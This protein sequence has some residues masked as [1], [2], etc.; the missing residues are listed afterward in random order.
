MRASDVRQLREEEKIILKKLLTGKVR[1][2]LFDK[3]VT[4]YSFAIF[5]FPHSLLVH[6]LIGS[7]YT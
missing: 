3:L 2:E 6:R 4:A 5:F 7:F 1:E